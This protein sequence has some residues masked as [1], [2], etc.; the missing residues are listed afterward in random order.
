VTEDALDTLLADVVALG[1][2]EEQATVRIVFNAYRDRG[3]D[4][5]FAWR[6]VMRALVPN[7]EA[8]APERAA[9]EEA[10]D[11]LREQKGQFRAA[12]ERRRPTRE[13]ITAGMMR[14]EQRLRDL[15]EFDREQRGAA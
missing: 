11:L 4:F 8:A 5:D 10:R 15:D 6:T 3:L 14:A 7:N 2:D 9:L 13:E 1:A 12:Y